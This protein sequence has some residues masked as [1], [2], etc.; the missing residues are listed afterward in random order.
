MDIKNPLPMISCSRERPTFVRIGS[1]WVPG[2]AGPV[3]DGSKKGPYR[4]AVEREAAIKK[5]PGSA[6][7]VR[8]GSRCRLPAPAALYHTLFGSGSAG[9]GYGNVVSRSGNIGGVYI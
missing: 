8:D 3:H 4:T 5:V 9:L 1:K 6:G 7:P 2:F